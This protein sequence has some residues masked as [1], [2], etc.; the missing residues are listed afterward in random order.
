ME[1]LIAE[2]ITIDGRRYH[3]SWFDP[4]FRPPLE[5]TTQAVA[6]CF[7]ADGKIVLVTLNDKDWTL[8]GG[9][10]ERGETLEQTLA[11]EVREEACASVLDCA[12]LG[13]QLVVGRLRWPLLAWTSWLVAELRL[14]GAAGF[15][16]S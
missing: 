8:P 7:T 10:V 1:R 3:I 6:A 2:T 14:A 15:K 9:T 13:C 16:P 11:R 5:H 12:Y 4:P